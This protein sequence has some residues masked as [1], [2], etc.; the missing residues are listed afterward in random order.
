MTKTAIPLRDL[1]QRIH[2][3]QAEL[4]KLRQEYKAR[5]TQMRELTRRKEQLQAQLRQ[6][7]AELRGLDEGHAAAPKPATAVRAAT[8][9][10]TGV[11]LAQLVVR[12][13][14]NAAGPIP[15]RELTREVERQKY[16]TTSSNLFGLV[17]KRVSELVKKGLLRRAKNHLG[18]LPPQRPEAS[19]GKP[20]AL[21]ATIKPK[22][23]ATVAQH[24][25]RA[26]PTTSPVVSKDGQSLHAIVTQVL[27]KSPHPLSAR[28]LATRVLRTGYKTES[29]DFTNL[30]WSGIGKMANIENV[31]GKGYRL[32]KGKTTVAGAK[33]KGVK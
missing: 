24:G 8:K 29:K 1:A 14:T 21:K 6:V 19:A 4:E 16:P 27:A 26:T 12:I 31:P 18:V 22:K 32:K 30:I 20:K 25:A 11:S 17:E 10:A 23:P 3:Q 13:V 2:N 33:G 9:P 7:D 15:L 28:E 5:Q